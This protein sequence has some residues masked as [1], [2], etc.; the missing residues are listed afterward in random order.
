MNQS[1]VATVLA[2]VFGITFGFPIRTCDKLK[3]VQKGV[4]NYDLYLVKLKDSKD[5]KYI[6]NIVSKYETTLEQ[7]SS[8][9]SE[10]SVQSKLELTGDLGMLYGVLSHQ[11]L[12]MVSHL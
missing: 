7:H 8:N 4:E 10:P 9:V 6:V 1:V 12:L 11:A 3:G 5:S 2:V